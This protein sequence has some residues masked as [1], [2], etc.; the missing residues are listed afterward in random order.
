MSISEWR[1]WV[2]VI[3]LSAA[4]AAQTGNPSRPADQP[5]VISNSATKIPGILTA[6]PQDQRKSGLIIFVQQISLN[7]N[8]TDSKE[9]AVL[10][11]L[12]ESLGAGGF[13]TI[14]YQQTSNAGSETRVGVEPASKIVD[15][16]VA[17]VQSAPD[18]LGGTPG[19]EFLLS[20]GVGA[21][22]A[23]YIAEKSP[24]VRGLIL[25]APNILPVETQLAEQTRRDLEKRRTPES[26]IQEELASQNK[27][28]SDIR[29]GKLPAGRLIEGAPAETW[30][31]WMNR[32]PA[33]ELGKLNLPILVLQ[34][35][36]DETATDANSEKLQKA[37]GT[38]G[39]AVEFRLFPNLNHSFSV[40]ASAGGTG[41]SDKLDPQVVTAILT[42]LSRHTH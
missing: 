8:G 36:R 15:D 34:A 6:P 19:P 10:R 40:A 31:D 5:I 4:V 21:T 13:A 16:G 35:G 3:V 14:R 9:T 26:E 30:L 17:V 22:V 27:I 39:P 12:A 1:Y 42:W 33:E 23:P 38:R 37:L 18:Q 29:A 11:N 28:L 7:E 24:N 25:V 2:P 20:Y 32:N 41:E